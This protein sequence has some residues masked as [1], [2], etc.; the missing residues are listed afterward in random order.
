[1][2]HERRLHLAGAR[3]LGRHAP[4]GV[5]CVCRVW[6]VCCV[7]ACPRGRNGCSACACVRRSRALLIR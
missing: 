1:M 7:G 5:A 4:S 2:Q 3:R 6:A